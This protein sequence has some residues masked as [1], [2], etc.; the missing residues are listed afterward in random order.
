MVIHKKYVV[1]YGSRGISNEFRSVSAAQKF[2]QNKANQRGEKVEIDRLTIYGRGD[3]FSQ[4]HEKYVKPNGKPVRRA[5]A[6]RRA[7]MFGG[8]FAMR[9]LGVARFRV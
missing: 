3:Q 2:A 9:P 6:P 7:G 1:L 8:G 5:T 4:G